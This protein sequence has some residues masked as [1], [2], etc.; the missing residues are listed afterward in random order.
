MKFTRSQIE[1]WNIHKKMNKEAKNE[2]RKWLNG[3]KK[4]AA[5]KEEDEW[6]FEQVLGINCLRYSS[7]IY[8]GPVGG[9]ISD[10]DF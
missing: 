6:Q 1:R 10:V 4:K 3:L 2:E 5:I 9:E 8:R 7:K